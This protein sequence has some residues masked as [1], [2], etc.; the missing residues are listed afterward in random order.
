[1]LHGISDANDTTKPTPEA[2]CSKL[3]K[4]LAGLNPTDIERG[5]EIIDRVYRLEDGVAG[6]WVTDLK[7][8]KRAVLSTSNSGAKDYMNLSLKETKV[9]LSSN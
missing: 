9:F 6:Q 4:K 2:C 8:F 7:D 3:N 5:K 1:M